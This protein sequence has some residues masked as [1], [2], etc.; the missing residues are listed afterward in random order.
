M[1]QPVETR[2]TPAVARQ[3]CERT[4]SAAVLEG[5]I[6]SLGSRYVLGLRATNCRT[7]D[8]LDQQQVQVARKE[9]V[10][11]GLSQAARE[12]RRRTG[13]SLKSVEK[14][15]TPLGEATTSSLEALR[16]YTAAFRTFHGSFDAVG[17][18][19]RAVEIDPTFAMAYAGL[20]RMYSDTGELALSA[21]NTRRAYE[22][23]DRTSPIKGNVKRHFSPSARC[24]FFSVSAF[25]PT[26]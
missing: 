2:L 12:F 23:R 21:E 25:S 13:E 26:V 19:K 8:I 18:L 15:D 20:G 7:G 14:Y 6:S 1:N 9:D 22:L 17:S 3:V 5:S 4:A 10:L 16:A 11:N 24:R